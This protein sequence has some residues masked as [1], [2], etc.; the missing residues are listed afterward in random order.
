MRVL[1]AT[2]LF[3][4]LALFTACIYEQKTAEPAQ[5]TPASSTPMRNQ[6]A[7]RLL[8]EARCDYEARCNRIGPNAEYA[9]RQH[10]LN[11][12]HDDAAKK[13]EDC[14]YGVKQYE[15]SSCLS[16]IR[17]Q[18]CGGV[19]ERID[20]VGRSVACRAGRICLD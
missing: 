12:A 5:M 7:A 19:S 20:A 4:A 8:S 6:R 17:N 2:V 1:S 9:S 11:V 3:G 16:D 10:C 13:L 18:D 14:R 15:L